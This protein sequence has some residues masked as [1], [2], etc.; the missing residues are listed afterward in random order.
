MVR[1]CIPLLSFF[2]CNC[3]LL[4]FWSHEVTVRLA[5]RQGQSTQKRTRIKIRTVDEAARVTGDSD[6]SD[7]D[8]TDSDATMFEFDSGF[9]VIAIDVCLH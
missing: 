1:S 4:F 2:D 5:T 7:D 8:D 6:D 3:C 9:N